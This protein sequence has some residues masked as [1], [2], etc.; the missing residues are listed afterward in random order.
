MDGPGGACS[1]GAIDVQVMFRGRGEPVCSPN[2]GADES[3]PMQI[4]I[5]SLNTYTRQPKR[6]AEYS[7]GPASMIVP[8]C[9]GLMARRG[10][11]DSVLDCVGD[12]E[13][14]EGVD[15]IREVA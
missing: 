1:L 13:Q 6:P 2:C 15:R 5:L 3:G 14:V 8:R 10:G 7:A 9:G 11:L 4:T 12:C